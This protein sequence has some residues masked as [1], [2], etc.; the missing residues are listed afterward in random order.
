MLVVSALLL[1]L[2]LAEKIENLRF[3]GLL[4]V[5]GIIFF[6]MAFI[7]YYI[8]TMFDSDI[9]AEPK[10]GM[11]MFPDDWYGAAAAVPNI[12]LSITF[13]NN[14]FPLFKGIKQANDKK[15]M[16]ASFVGV[17]SSAATYLA[18][19]I[20]GY[21]YVGEG[22]EPNFLESFNYN[23]I[24]KPFYFL[25]N[26][27]FLLSIFFAFPIMFFGCRNNFIA[28]IK[29]AL[30]DDKKTSKAWRS[31][32][33]VEEISTYIRNEERGQRKKRAKLHFI[34]YTLLLYLAMVGVAVGLD[35]I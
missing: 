11:R 17:F 8:L 21:N 27:F 12:L 23:E 7:L 4:G 25:L 20:M 31:E 10:G 16:Q 34:L 30:T 6:M 14:F 26:G 2:T 28:L 9:G 18:I 33:N 5:F 24:S 19:G 1:P 13:Q 35:D 15:M 29:L 32:D 22:V 3:M